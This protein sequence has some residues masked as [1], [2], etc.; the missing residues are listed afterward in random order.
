[1]VGDGVT[2]TVI[3]M[4]WMTAVAAVLPQ[5]PPTAEA[6]LIA[7][8][9]RA[10]LG[11]SLALNA[12]FLARIAR[13]VGENEKKMVELEKLW[14][15]HQAEWGVWREVLH[16]EFGLDRR[17]GTADRRQPDDIPRITD[18]RSGK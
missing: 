12:Y 4:S 16:N 14:I 18:K 7:W 2:R 17:V 3:G 6:D 5:T 11:S 10:V 8:A 9:V 15:A 1:M 13:L